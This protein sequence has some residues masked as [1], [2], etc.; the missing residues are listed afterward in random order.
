MNRYGRDEEIGKPS[1][2]PYH[3]YSEGLVNGLL[4]L[5]A[6]KMVRCKIYVATHKNSS[7]IVCMRC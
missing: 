2:A 1:R 7:Y 4:A 5:S 6:G 3:R